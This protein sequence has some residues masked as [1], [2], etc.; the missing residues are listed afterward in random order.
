MS[1]ARKMMRHGKRLVSRGVTTPYNRPK[2][3]RKGIPYRRL[4]S[5]NGRAVHATKGTSHHISVLAYRANI[6][7]GGAA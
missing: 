5:F 2:A 7:A 4:L 3:F 6:I 1:L